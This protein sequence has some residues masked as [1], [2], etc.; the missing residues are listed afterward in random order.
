[1][2][3]LPASL[4]PGMFCSPSRILFGAGSV[5]GLAPLLA[6]LGHAGAALVTD[7]YF[8][9]QSPHVARIVSDLR[10][11]GIACTVFAGGQ[12]DPSLAL[13]D[14]ATR[15]LHRMGGHPIDCVIALGGGSNIDLA[16]VL[17][18]TL[19]SRSPAASFVGVSRFPIK[20][21]PLIAVPTTAGTAS[22]I[23]P[24][25]I[26]VQDANSPKVAVMGNE[27]RAM[28]AVVDPELT[29]SCP[30]RVTAD[31]G[32]DALTHAIESYV[33]LDFSEFDRAGDVDPGY[34][35]RNPI[36]RLFARESIALGFRY[37]SRAYRDGGDIEARTGMCMS[38]LYAGLSYATA[39]LNAVHALAYG[40]TA[41][42]HETHGRTNAVLLPYV[43][44]AI[45]L[46]RP[47]EVADIATMAEGEGSSRN[48][49]AG[50]DAGT[51]TSVPR[52]TAGEQLRCLVREVGI[53]DTLAGF[54]VT[55]EQLPSI[56]AGGLAVTR[57]VKAFPRPDAPARFHDIVRN[58]YHGYMTQP[59]LP[60]RATGGARSGPALH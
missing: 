29:L 23:T 60:E 50:G 4:Q 51:T 6:K 28:V 22:E 5:G 42:T 41:V 14:E 27:L 26:L 9:Q 8:E 31:A 18:L 56:V 2:I 11:E 39:G 21:L 17:C 13:C 30:P 19:P 20:P 32:M 35:G 36:T 3:S 48:G 40:L 25:A 57:L 15:S 53:P 10:R 46:T 38:S 16:K 59:G 43:I 54:G 7:A 52:L 24:G 33:T 1:M 45:A 44:D 49:A 37:L 55:Q 34:S 58:A 47:H 12:P